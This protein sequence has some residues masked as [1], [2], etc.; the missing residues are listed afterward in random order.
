MSSLYVLDISHSLDIDL[1]IL[2]FGLILLVS[3]AVCLPLFKSSGKEVCFRGLRTV[4]MW[5]SP[6]LHGYLTENSALKYQLYMMYGDSTVSRIG[7]RGE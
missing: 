4:T 5:V 7:G 6:Q 1:Q 3:F 2:K